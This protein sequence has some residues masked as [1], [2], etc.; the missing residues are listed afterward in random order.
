MLRQVDFRG[1]ESRSPA[2]LENGSRTPAVS[3][4]VPTRNEAGNIQKLVECLES[5]ARD[6]PLE[7]VFVDDSTDDTPAVIEAM[8]DEA[9]S[10]IVL[11]HRTPEQRV[12][13]LGGAVIEGLRAARA[14]YACVMDADLQHP[15]AVIAELF[16]KAQETDADVVVASRYCTNGSAGSF[17]MLRAAVSRASG[18]AAHVFFPLRLRGVSDPMSGFFLVRRD[19]VELERLRPRGFKILLEILVR[20]SGLRVAEVPFEFGKRF[21]GESKASLREGVRYLGHL[22]H[23]RTAASMRFARFGIVGAT[24]LAVNMAVIF[25]L[26]EVAGLFY[27]LSAI[28][29]TQA[30]T[31]WNFFFTDRWVFPDRERSRGVWSRMWMFFAMNNAALPLRVPLMFLLTSLL[32][33]HYMIS[34]VFSLGVIAVIRYAFSDS[35]IWKDARRRARAHS[36][37]VHGIVSVE[38]QVRLP[39]LERFRVQ[40]RLVEPTIRVRIGKVNGKDDS[41][42]GGNG[43][44]HYDEGLG[45]LGFATDITVGESIDVV[46]SKLLKYSPH[47]L[48]TNVVEPILRWTF[49]ERGYALVHGACMETGGDA[50]LVTARTDTG[51]TTTIL[52][53]LGSYDHCSFLS[54]DL[55]LVSPDGRVMTY[56]KPLTISRHTVSALS[57]HSLSK[58]ER[59]WLIFQSR[60]HSKSGRRFAFGLT[61]AKLPV[62]TINAI[63]QMIV[64]PPKYDVSRLVP[65]VTF[66]DEAR[67]AGLIVIERNG[68]QAVPLN[69]G[70]ALE[71]LM[72]NCEDAY[73]FPPYHQIEHFLHSRNGSDLR[74]AEREIVASALSG[75]AATRL[76]SQKRDWW[77]KLGGLMTPVASR[78][79]P[80]TVKGHLAPG[81]T[82]FE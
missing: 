10:R 28:V 4:I 74:A 6:L 55:T 51:K 9:R 43:R 47:V 54:D 49:V 19:A 61:R 30:S 66:V 52:K 16:A 11:I 48:Y 12:G 69:G 24:G 45:S 15:P 78:P 79:F 60:V 44:L 63:V 57:N 8:R 14:P 59:F 35:I 20:T 38:S 13:G 21:A 33:V 25:A 81:I 39:E 41:G 1:R 42:D 73:G 68:D 46:A 34:N 5:V 22:A 80:Q 2:E 77:Q 26:T 64:P 7:I 62:A 32:G 70:E 3:V 71:T 65:G 17:G 82:A 56:P 75:V 18:S 50:F 27:L 40:R 29:A 67:L 23:L 37:D 36:Y 58:W 76:Q 53:S 72:R 31:L